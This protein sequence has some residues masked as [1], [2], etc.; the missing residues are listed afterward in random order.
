MPRIHLHWCRRYDPEMGMS[1]TKNG[2][3]IPLLNYHPKSQ[4][5]I[6]EA[7]LLSGTIYAGSWG[8]G[9]MIAQNNSW[10]TTIPS[11]V[12]SGNYL[13]RFETIALHS[14]PAVSLL[15]TPVNLLLQFDLFYSKCTPNVPRSPSLVAAVWR[16]HLRS[17]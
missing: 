8:A 9:K 1:I 7:G 12:P 16:R 2:F 3:H 11:T 13:I 14:L 10:T 6:D 15:V 5:K 4:F 17:L